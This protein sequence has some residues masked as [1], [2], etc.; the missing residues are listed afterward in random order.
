MNIDPLSSHG[1]DKFETKPSGKKKVDSKDL[2]PDL[3][4]LTALRE[5]SPGNLEPKSPEQQNQKSKKPSP[6]ENIKEFF[7]KGIE[8]VKASFKG[9]AIAI[10]KFFTKKP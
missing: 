3:D 10:K 5:R 2:Q 9:S 6:I 4:E 7:K 1:Y 8:K